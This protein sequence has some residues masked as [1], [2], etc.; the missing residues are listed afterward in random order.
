MTKV[1]ATIDC[2]K[3][4]SQILKITADGSH[5]LFVPSLNEHYHSVFGALQESMHVFINTGYREVS[6]KRE[7]I[8]LLEIGF[9][10]GLN[11]LLTILNKNENEITYWAIEAYPLDESLISK[12]NYPEITN[13]SL[14]KEIFSQLH[15]AN[16]NQITEIIQGFYLYKIDSEI[17][18]LNL[19]E[20]HFHLVYFDAFAPEIQPELWTETIF[21]KIFHS[22][23]PGGILVTYSSKGIVKQNLRQA[24]FLVERLKG[25][26]GKRHILKAEKPIIN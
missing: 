23:I 6:K 18:S 17:Q 9:G 24:G 12:L 22:L 20:N 26:Y 21:L 4:K 11:A 14:D 15:N 10:T 16:W 25:A 1:R 2:Q 19:P 8:N 5:T 3:T 7:K 13:N